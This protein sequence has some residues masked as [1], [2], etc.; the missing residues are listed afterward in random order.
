MDSVFVVT[1]NPPE[2]LS[3]KE[4]VLSPPTFL[5]EVRACVRKKG[6]SATLGPNYLRA[7]ADEIGR[8]YDKFFNPYRNVVPQDFVGR[9]C[10]SDEEIAAVVHNMFQAT[11][12]IIYEKYYETIL[13]SR[14]FNTRVIYFSGDISHVT[15][16]NRLGIRKISIDDVP[17]YIGVIWPRSVQEDAVHSTKSVDSASE[18]I[19]PASISEVIQTTHVAAPEQ[20][21]ILEELA[22]I[23]QQERPVDVNAK[24]EK[25]RH[26]RSLNRQSSLNRHVSKNDAS[27]K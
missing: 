6:S 21:I 4:M 9:I 24:T 14:P 8:K 25:S 18:Q 17:S 20:S 26:Q 22:K 7:I 12:P 5:D 16:F 27:I 2:T 15:V 10:E 19:T 13:R 23:D 11:Y 3:D 1:S